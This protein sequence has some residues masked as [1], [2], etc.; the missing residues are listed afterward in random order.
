MIILIF[1]MELPLIWNNECLR[2]EELI[3]D[4]GGVDLQLLGIGQNGHI[5]FNEPGTPFTS[6][7][8]LVTLAQ[9]TRE[10]NSRFFQLD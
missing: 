1:Q 7:T 5:G 3:K 2:Y 4:L 9:D 8:H 6:R 10:A